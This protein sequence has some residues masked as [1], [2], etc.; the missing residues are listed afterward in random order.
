[1]VNKM[2]YVKEGRT[3][4]QEM[5]RDNVGTHASSAAFFIF[6]SLIPILMLIFSILP[7]TPLKE[8]DLMKAITEILPNSLDSMGIKIVREF[9]GKSSGIISIAAIVIIWSASKGLLAIM[10]GLNAIHNVIENR[11]YF[12]LRFWASIYTLLMLLMILLSLS[13]IVFGNVIVSMIVKQLPKTKYII[14]FLMMFRFV[15]VWAILT[16]LFMCLF[17]WIPNRRTKVKVQLTGA[18]FT[19]IGWSVFSYGFS[20]YIDWSNGFNMYGSLTTIIIIML[21]LYICMY[22]VLIG[23]KIN[24]WMENRKLKYVDYEIV[25]K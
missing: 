22:M 16:F 4:L 3:F 21:W 13:I 14:E 24:C 7:Y 15:F 10:R 8:A 1:M 5:K 18:V 12:V 2:N 23:A 9:Y 17:A 19:A 6:L 25:E 20:I 11:N